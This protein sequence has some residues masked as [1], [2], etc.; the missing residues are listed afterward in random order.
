MASLVAKR[1]P[2]AVLKT[3]H[4]PVDAPV[5][6]PMVPSEIPALD[7]FSW[8]TPEAGLDAVHAEGAAA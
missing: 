3:V 5:K 6:P 7:G 8:T 4:P 2:G 1:Y